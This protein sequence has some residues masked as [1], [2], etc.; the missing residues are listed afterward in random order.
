MIEDIVAFANASGGDLVIGVQEDR[1]QGK[2]T[3]RAAAIPG[4]DLG[5]PDQ[6]KLAI[7]SSLRDRLEPKLYGLRYHFVQVDDVSCV[8]IIRV[9]KS[10]QF[11]LIRKE[12][13]WFKSV[14]RN[15]AGNWVY[16]LFR[17]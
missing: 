13:M 5:S 17:G 8:A 1:E 14:G 12:K 15:A 6:F 9:P 11:H 7:E 16:R 4:F 10:H 3:G 2:N